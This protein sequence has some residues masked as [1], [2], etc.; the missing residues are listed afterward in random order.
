MTVGVTDEA[1]VARKLL[2]E[3]ICPTEIRIEGVRTFLAN[4]KPSLELNIVPISDPFGPAIT[5]ES[6]E[7]R[8]DTLV[9]SFI[10]QGL[11]YFKIRYF[12]AS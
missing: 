2:P 4:L 8:S 3:L 10:R 9:L 6:L 11:K 5:D 7:A 1:M 12:S